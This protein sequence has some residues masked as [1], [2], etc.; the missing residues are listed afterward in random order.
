M[1]DYRRTISDLGQY[2]FFFA[3][4]RHLVHL[5]IL[6]QESTTFYKKTEKIDVENDLWI[7]GKD[8]LI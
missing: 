2:N 4:K 1:E 7:M 8:I 6:S 5:G 3:F